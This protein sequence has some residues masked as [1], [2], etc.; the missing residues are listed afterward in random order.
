MYHIL[1]SLS[2]GSYQTPSENTIAIGEIKVNPLTFKVDISDI[3]IPA[4]ASP[5]ESPMVA[6]GHLRLGFSP[7]SLLQEAYR[8]TE[9]RIDH[10][11]VQATI[12]PDGALNLLELVPPSHG[13][14]SPA[15]VIDIFSVDQGRI[16]YADRSRP[17]GPEETLVPITF[18]L[19]DF[20]T[21]KNEGGEFT[22][23]SK[24]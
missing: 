14:E 18:T 20:H 3:A 21:K 8:L 2:F 12:R 17:A 7:L 4:T 6:V 10:P 24:S 22:L 5:K 23:D 1:N 13:G 9:L 15:V 16:V 11:F 19:R